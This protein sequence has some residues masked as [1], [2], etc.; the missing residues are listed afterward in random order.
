MDISNQYQLEVQ[1]SRAEIKDYF[2][3][4][5][6]LPEYREYLDFKLVKK[7]KVKAWI[8]VCISE[9]GKA[10]SLPQVPF[11]GI[12]M[13]DSLSSEALEYFILIIQEELRKRGVLELEITQAPKP[14]Q[15]NHDL[16]NYLLFKLGFRQEKVLA[17]QFFL[18]KKKI[19]KLIQSEQDR[20]QKRIKEGELTIRKGPISNFGFLQEIRSWNK[21]R[22]YD[23]NLD[24]T[25]LITQVSEYPER[26]FLISLEKKGQAV[27]Q[28][29]ATR[30][31]SESLYYFQ[32]AIDPKSQL[33]QGGEM[34]LYQL[35]IL[36]MDLKVD[37]IDL[38]S[39][40]QPSS[41]NHNLMFFKSRF[42]NDI[43]NK[44]TWVRKL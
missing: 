4:N 32:S 31:T 22:G 21:S 36:A 6:Q 16:V 26:Y 13:Q 43:S 5:E 11:G 34:L 33:K 39:S 14:Y 30:L 44:V 12:W 35:F 28:T 7:E 42:S 3:A 1:D 41:A 25:R 19:K 40:D 29:L 23:S 9:G 10:I 20:F 17:H 38:G 2:L 37:F 27:A 15:S 8:T 18:G 24:E